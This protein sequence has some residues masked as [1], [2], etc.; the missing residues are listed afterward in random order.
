ML[1]FI[2]QII[3]L[4]GKCLIF[5]CMFHGQSAVERGFNTNAGC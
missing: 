5:F 4:F 2:L 1:N 3:H